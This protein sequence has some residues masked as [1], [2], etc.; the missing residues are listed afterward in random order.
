MDFIENSFIGFIPVVAEGLPV[1]LQ[2]LG[3]ALGIG[4]P[5]G[6]L[7]ALLSLNKSRVLQTIL[8]IIIEVGRGVPIL[9]F[10]YLFYQ[11]LTRVE[12]NISPF[13][14]ASL[15]FIW[16][17]A[18]Y[19]SE[20]FKGGIHAVPRGQ[21]DA[22]AADGFRQI[23]RY[24]YIIFPQAARISL[25]PVMNLAI[26]TFQFTALTYVITLPD[27]M[28]IANMK[29]SQ[30]FRY[31]DLYVAAACIYLII[32]LPASYLVTLL[33]RKANNRTSASPKSGNDGG[34]NRL[35]F[36]QR[37]TRSIP[38]QQSRRT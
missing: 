16:S 1:A 28:M 9:V 23:D 37:F 12:I 5:L 10:L 4:L 31:M 11:G 20:V 29:G 38:V 34:N 25:A 19:S 14:A 2:V 15:V 13:M 18:A 22:A 24:F 3:I 6:L 36:G 17:T 35:W 27:I 26:Q 8:I 21:W 7:L 33:D 30:T 32:C